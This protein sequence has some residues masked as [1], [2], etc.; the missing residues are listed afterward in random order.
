MTAM[1]S[2]DLIAL[3]PL[4]VL[5]F[6]AVLAMLAI[7][8]RRS[9]RTTASLALVGLAGT[10]ASLFAA[11]PLSPRI[12]TA[13]IVIDTY[14]LFFIGLIV[15]ATFAI[16]LFAYS[17]FAR[18]NE[19]PEELYVLLLIAA[20]G[21]SVLAASRH[22][23]SFFLGLE[24]LSVSLY[25]LSGYLRGRTQALEAGLK[26]LVLAAASAA[27]LLLGM[28]LIY[29]EMGTME[30]TGIRARL[31]SAAFGEHLLLV[32]GVAL[33]LTGIG[34]KLAL[35]PFHFWTPDVYQGA[36][37]PVTAL[38]ATVSKGGMFAALVRLFYRSGVQDLKGVFLVLAIL[39]I[40]SMLAGNLLALLQTNIKRLLAY[41]SISHMGYLLVALLAGG[42]LAVQAVSFYLVAYFVSILGAFGV[43]TVLSTSER[44][45]DAL[46]DYRA[47]I[48]RRPV[49]AIILTLMLLSLA[50]IPLTAGFLGKFFVVA[51][52]ASAG[53]WAL[54]IVL[55]ASSVIGF[56]YYL[57]VIVA[58]YSRRAAEETHEKAILAP[59]GIGGLVILCLGVLLVWLGVYPGPLA[60]LARAVASGMS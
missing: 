40:A 53:R 26:Y 41:S 3:L 42:N 11:A 31:L 24:T 25:A 5:A 29:F 55:V 9:H 18:Q 57:R 37:A 4:E 20:F 36:S 6:A 15:A 48:S 2:S 43:I 60:A 51:A 22:F 14:A 17:Y 28:A 33:M 54:L 13:L 30:F 23:A 45:A 56:F 16:I 34:F 1:S 19:R 49:L 10:F 50:G 47:L 46:E 38:I 35:V 32:P 7:A 59:F 58:I 12:V 27:F 8:W 39:A 44:D 21:S 52:G